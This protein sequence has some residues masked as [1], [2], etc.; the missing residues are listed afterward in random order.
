M[1]DGKKNPFSEWIEKNKKDLSYTYEKE[2][3]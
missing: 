3:T 1:C 2:N